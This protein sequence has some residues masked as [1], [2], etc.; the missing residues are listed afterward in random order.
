MNLRKITI[1]AGAALSLA[2]V[3]T[4]VALAAP[5]VPHLLGATVGAQENGASGQSEKQ[6]NEAGNH[7]D[8]QSGQS[9]KQ[10][11]QTGNHEEGASDQSDKQD[12]KTGAAVKP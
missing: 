11:G 6:D 1:A 3:G 2:V 12:K 4:I 8:G 10:E 5:S 7:E 9:D